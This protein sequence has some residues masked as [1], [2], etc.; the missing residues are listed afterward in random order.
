MVL[1]L[2]DR[3]K[4]QLAN[5]TNSTSLLK[6]LWK[7]SAQLLHFLLVYLIQKLLDLLTR[8]FLVVGFGVGCENLSEI[9]GHLEGLRAK[10]TGEVDV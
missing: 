1:L 8:H 9:A 6:R 2:L 7:L 5:L 10:L 3:N 4:I